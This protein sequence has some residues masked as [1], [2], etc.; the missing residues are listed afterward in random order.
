MSEAVEPQVAGAAEQQAV[1]E[2][3]GN[4]PLYVYIAFLAGVIFPL[5]AIVGVIIAHVYRTGTSTVENSHYS[6]QIRTFWWGLL[7][8]LVGSVLSVVVIGYLVI[9]GW[10]GWSIYRSIKGM[11]AL[12]EGQ[13]I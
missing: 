7:W 6:Y 10:L 2:K 4:M 9:L 3:P 8:C 1:S 5:A 13:A 11:K 12:S